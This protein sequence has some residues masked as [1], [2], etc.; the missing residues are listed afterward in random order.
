VARLAVWEGGLGIP[1]GLL[2]GVIAGVVV[3][4]RCGLPA[5][6]LL[7]VVAPGIRVAQAIG[8]LG[9]WFNQ[10]LFGRPTDL[11]WALR[12]DPEHRPAGYA[13][14]ATYPRRSSLRGTV[15]PRPGPPAGR[16]GSTISQPAAGAALRPLRGRLRPGPPLGRGPLRIEPATR[17]LGVRVNIWTSLAAFTC[18]ATWLIVTRPRPGSAATEASPD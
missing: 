4:R 17:L 15:E 9:N 16:L 14:V 11:P 8:R 2:A 5:A 13:D 1:G 3:A 6:E 7:D 12:I 10:E 18:A